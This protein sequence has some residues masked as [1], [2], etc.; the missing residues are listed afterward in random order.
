MIPQVTKHEFD[1]VQLF[2][3]HQR[4]II[5]GVVNTTPDSFSD[6]GNFLDPTLAVAHALRLVSEGADIIDIGGESSRPGS[7][8]VSEFEELRRVIPVIQALAGNITMPISVDTYKSPVAR[9]ALESGATIVNDITALTGDS[10]MAATVAEFDAG[11]VLM[12]MRGS[13]KEMQRN[14]GYADLIGEI[15]DFLASAIRVAEAAGVNPDKIM[16]DPGIGF[17]KDV[18]GNLAIIKSVSRFKQLGKSVLIG[19]S[20]KSFIGRISGA[21]TESRLAGSLAAAV[22][23]VLNGAD[24]VRVHDVLE[25][26]QAV[27]MALKLRKDS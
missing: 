26:R 7:D 16:I 13:P 9:K 6:G 8:P 1:L 3:D 5:M 23:A 2:K 19:A 22:A 25:T 18:D 4:T 27:D 10:K 24:A 20:R 15:S 21:T 12:H 17:G 14:T 11:L